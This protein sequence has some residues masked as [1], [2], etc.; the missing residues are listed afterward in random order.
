M[1]YNC[2]MKYIKSNSSKNIHLSERSV[3]RAPKP[4]PSWGWSEEQEVEEQEE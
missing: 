2:F 3:W 4:P 1:G